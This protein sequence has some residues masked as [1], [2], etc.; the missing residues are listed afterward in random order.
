[1]GPEA[2]SR[3]SA[4]VRCIAAGRS[5][6]ARGGVMLMGRSLPTSRSRV[7]SCAV[8]LNGKPITLMQWWMDADL[9]D[10][11]G[12]CRLRVGSPAEY[13]CMDSCSFPRYS[14]ARHDNHMRPS[15]NTWVCARIFLGVCTLESC[16][17]SRWRTYLRSD[18][19][20]LSEHV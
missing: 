19:A 2:I 13:R 14:S 11:L 9:T 3:S 10:R 1:M 7:T 4:G 15:D 12:S 16:G 5:A 8:I 20:A 6:S 17:D 18:L